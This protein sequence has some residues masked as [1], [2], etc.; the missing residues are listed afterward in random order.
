MEADLK[1]RMDD[2]LRRKLDRL[3]S[4]KMQP[5]LHLSQTIDSLINSID[6]DAERQLLIIENKQTSVRERQATVNGA[7]CEFVRILKAL[8]KNLHTR[9]LTNQKKELGKDFVA[10]E[11]RVNE[12]RNTSI[13][14]EDD[15]YEF[16][17]S[18]V[19][20][21]LD[22]DEM[23]NKVESSIF[24][25]QTIVYL[26]STDDQSELGSL[27]HLTGVS[28]TTEQIECLK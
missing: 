17:D 18:F 6:L 10:L 1:A 7:R 15:M 21:V 13:S 23:T 26:S 2:D 24:D 14:Q 25:N 8:E 4:M 27:F 28:L 16:E 19:Q 3:Y 9:L 12:F 20:L 11:E 22:M 5:A